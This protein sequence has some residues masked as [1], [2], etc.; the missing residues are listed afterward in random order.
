MVSNHLRSLCFRSLTNE[1]APEKCLRFCLSWMDQ[2]ISPL[3]IQYTLPY[4]FLFVI[5]LFELNEKTN[6]HMNK[7]IFYYPLLKLTMDD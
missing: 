6:K 1:K 3:P 5:T 7:V 2:R 4:S